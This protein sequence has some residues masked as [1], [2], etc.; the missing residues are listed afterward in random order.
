MRKE[1]RSRHIQ[2]L[3]QKA[4]FGNMVDKGTRERAKAQ[5]KHKPYAAMLIREQ[6]QQ[7]EGREHGESTTTERK[8]I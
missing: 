4:R 5:M 1:R 6:G 2:R 3:D 8:E 7:M